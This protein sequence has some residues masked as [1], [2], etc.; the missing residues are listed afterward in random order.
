[1][2]TAAYVHGDNDSD[3][4]PLAQ[5]PPL[6]TSL[7]VKYDDGTFLGGLLLRAVAGQDRFDSGWGNIVGQDFGRTGG[8]AVLSA[9]G[10]WR[11]RDNIRLTGG[12]DNIL[13]KTYAEHVSKSEPVTGMSAL[14]DYDKTIRVNEPGRTFWMKGNITF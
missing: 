6:D 1:E 12:V 13:D 4:T 10:G 14:A 11:I 2:A 3:N 7:A 5:T 9:N 8:F